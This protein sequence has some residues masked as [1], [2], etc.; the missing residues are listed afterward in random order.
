MTLIVKKYYEDKLFATYAKT[1]NDTFE[2]NEVLSLF[3]ID[4]SVMDMSFDL[5]KDQIHLRINIDEKS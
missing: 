1:V 3:N 5:M 2:Y 4:M